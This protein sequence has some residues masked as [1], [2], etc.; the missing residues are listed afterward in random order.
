MITFPPSHGHGQPAFLLSHRK[1][2][3][4]SG[5]NIIFFPSGIK[6]EGEEDGWFILSVLV[7]R[8]LRYKHTRILHPLKQARPD[9]KP[10]ALKQ[11]YA[12]G[13]QLS[14]F[15]TSRLYPIRPLSDEEKMMMMM[16]IK[17]SYYDDREKRH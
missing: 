9:H 1:G 17:T 2:G 15:S 8:T 13:R 16:M 14:S 10:M 4:F 3:A 5:D 12:S 11:E 7:L 6:N